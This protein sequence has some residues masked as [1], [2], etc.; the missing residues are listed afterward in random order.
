MKDFKQFIK[1]NYQE[2]RRLGTRQPNLYSSEPSNVVGGSEIFNPIPRSPEYINHGHFKINGKPIDY[3]TFPKFGTVEN[4]AT[5]EIT[6]YQETVSKKV[7]KSKI[8]GEFPDHDPNIP[9]IIR[10][11][12][13]GE[14]HHIL[15]DGNHRVAKNRFVRIKNTR[16]LVVGADDVE[17]Y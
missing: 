14:T 17:E 10:I 6:S 15:Y 1:E 4:V 8:R 7:I 9:Y 3:H 11:K 12:H 5:N 16:A 13:N 2:R